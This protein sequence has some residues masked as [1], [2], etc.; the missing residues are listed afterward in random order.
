MKKPYSLNFEIEKDTERLAHIEHVLDTV[1]RKPTQADLELMA[2]Y[3]LYGRDDNGQNA[4][5]RKEI[6]DLD[7]RYKTFRTRDERNE[8]LDELME[9]PLVDQT[10]FHDIG[11]KTHYLRRLTKIERPRYAPDGTLLEKGDSDI[12]GM[13]ELWKSI[14]R[15][16]RIVAISEG[17]ITPRED[18]TDILAQNSYNLYQLKHMLVDLRRQQYYLK[19]AYKPALRFLN[20]RSGGQHSIDFTSDAAYWLSPEE[21]QQKADSYLLPMDRDPDHHEHRTLPDGTTEIKWTIRHQEFDWENIEHI[22]ALIEYYGAIYQQNYD[23][24]MSWGRTLIYDFDRYADAANLTEEQEYILMRRIDHASY[25]I[26]QQEVLEKFGIKYSDNHICTIAMHQIPKAMA[27]AARKRRLI[28]ETPDSEKKK[29]TRC[30]R[31]LP[32][33]TAFFT[34]HGERKDGLASRCKECDRERRIER[35]VISGKKLKTATVPKVQAD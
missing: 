14:D 16:E 29:C 33:D 21:W 8:S 25:P 19:D 2:S 6:L 4:V 18:E 17:K 27:L 22:K 15:L 9:S 28:V 35:G 1:E 24:T 7:K 3:I 31:L 11:T 5:Q 30:G 20:T 32:R 12:P 34:L 13:V 26:I 23:D 10:T